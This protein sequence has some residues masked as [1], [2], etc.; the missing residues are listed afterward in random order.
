[1]IRKLVLAASVAVAATSLAEP[2]HAAVFGVVHGAAVGRFGG[3]YGFRYGAYRGGGYW[4]GGYYGGC[5][6]G[7]A[8][9]AGAVAGA[10]V[11]AA[12][13]SAYTAPAAVY[14]SPPAVYVAPPV[15]YGSRGYYYVRCRLNLS[16]RALIHEFDVAR[17]V[18]RHPACLSE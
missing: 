14:A 18:L 10:A 2:A 16:R 17:S 9:A 3:G 7:G 1:M 11:G 5:C 6:Y 4:R 8:I 15:V 12:A 13:T